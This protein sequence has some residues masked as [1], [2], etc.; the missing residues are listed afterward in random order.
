MNTENVIPDDPTPEEFAEYLNNIIKR[1]EIN[2]IKGL[3]GYY[4]EKK[5]H[6]KEKFR[7]L[8]ESELNDLRKE[9][10]QTPSPTGD[11]DC[12]ELKK[13]VERLKGIIKT[14]HDRHLVTKKDREGLWQYFAKT[15]NL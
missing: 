4:D 10:S 2:S 1:N 6:L 7:Q 5:E 8:E 12:D 9:K 13:E 14:L 3:N 15:N 11:R